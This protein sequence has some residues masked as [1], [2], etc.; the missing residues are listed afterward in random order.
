MKGDLAS[1]TADIKAGRG[2]QMLLVFG[3]DLQV[4]DA[5]NEIVNLLVREDQRGFNLERFDGRT[6]SWDRVEASL[7]TPPFFPG[8]KVLWVENAPYFFSREQNSELGEKVLQLWS[9]GKQEEAGKLLFDLLAF[10]G[11]T[12]EQWEQLRSQSPGALVETLGSESAQTRREVEALIEYCKSRRMQFTAR[13]AG[14]DHRLAE[15]LDRGLPEWDFLLL[16]AV[17]VDRRTRLYK[18]L[19]EMRLTLNL[20]VER[21][22]TGKLSRESL[23]E[24]IGHRLRKAG[25]SLDAQAGE[26]IMSRAADDMRALGQ[27]LDKIVLYVGERTAIR[28]Q[29]VEAVM[30]DRGEGWIFD[31]TRSI[32]ERDALDALL[33]LARLM[34]QGE[35][36]LK[37][38]GALASELRRLLV[39]RQL[40]E[41]DLRGR[42]RRGITYAQFQQNVLQQ[43]APLLSRNGYADYMCFQ[44]AASFSLGAL[45]AH[46]KAVHEADLHLKSSAGEPRL[47]MEKLIFA[48]CL[49]S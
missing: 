34:T 44:R 33:H 32:A 1:V 9:E 48:M 40:L 30:A 35:H 10:E 13:K 5:C 25:K 7:L 23:M 46:L 39:A 28:P 27:E 19:E 42:W 22:K 36:P 24:F 45:L 16:T 17:Q 3:D 15:I 49:R 37:L 2:P 4:Q 6:A 47:V 20:T 8:K 11:W 14:Q 12:E 26:M 18:R 43:G 29:D 31:L 38:L 21:D 41:T